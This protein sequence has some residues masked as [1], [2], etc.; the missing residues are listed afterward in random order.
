MTREETAAWLERR[1]VAM[2][3]HDTAFLGSL[4]AEDCVVD[5]PTAGQ[6][7]K[8]RAAVEVIYRA[9]F[10]GFPDVTFRPAGVLIDGDRVASIVTAAGVD[11][12]GFMGLP[13]T[14]KPFTAQIALVS[15]LRDNQIVWE[16]RIYDFT[17]LL[18]QVG[19]LKARAG[20]NLPVGVEM[21]P[22]VLAGSPPLT[23]SSPP[24]RADALALVAARQEAWAS[25][26]AP[27]IARQHADDC[28]MD[29]HLAGRVEGPSAVQSVY[30]QWFDAFPDGVLASEAVVIDGEQVAEVATM[31]GTDTGGFLGLAPTGKPFKLPSVWLFT[32]RDG[33]FSYAR[34]IYD[35]TGLLVQIG[36]LKAKPI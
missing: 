15:T 26:D 28:V 34:P 2:S 33:H 36:I 1:Q 35:F 27:A 20:A 21:A 3:R 19:I 32:I 18:L 22:R 23:T 8:G 12:G 13:P 11:T 7:V 10:D 4:Y 17:R 29:S 24:S 14:G 30:T 5:S 25:R 31:S 16:R 6:S 9:W